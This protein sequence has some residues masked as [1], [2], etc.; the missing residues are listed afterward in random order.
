MHIVPS[1]FL[2]TSSDHPHNTDTVIPIGS[3]AEYISG[4]PHN[5][6]TAIPSGSGGEYICGIPHNTDTAISSGSGGEYIEDRQV[7]APF[8]DC[9]KD[10]H[11][12]TAML[13]MT[14]NRLKKLCKQHNL[15]TTGNKRDLVNRLRNSLSHLRRRSFSYP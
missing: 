15:A 9:S 7:K 4:D 5:T 12:T 2:P 10:D 13:Q 6:D 11:M 8:F 3:G 1:S 14:A